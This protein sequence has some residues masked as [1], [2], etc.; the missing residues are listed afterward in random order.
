MYGCRRPVA[1]LPTNPEC[2]HT[3]QDPRD[4]AARV[5]PNKHN[6]S[7]TPRQQLLVQQIAVV[8][9]HIHCGSVFELV[10]SYTGT[11]TY[12]IQKHTHSKDG[13]HTREVFQA[14]HSLSHANLHCSSA[15]KQRNSTTTASSRHT[16]TRST[17]T[18]A[19]P[20]AEW[21]SPHV[22]WGMQPARPS[23][24][25][26]CNSCN[27]FGGRAS[28]PV[29]THKTRANTHTPQLSCCNAG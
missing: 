9:A 29:P 20:W 6:V 5:Q 10:Q 15:T 14:S 24:R 3:Q 28:S 11:D 19:K 12:N 1:L 8:T 7:N 26:H 21:C 22:L 13:R 18:C 25:G 23:T 16:Q 27:E 4:L 17:Q 2:P